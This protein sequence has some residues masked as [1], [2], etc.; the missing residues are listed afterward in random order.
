MKG[1]GENY[2]P[3]G[4]PASTI[5]T[6]A[7]GGDLFGSFSIFLNPPIRFVGNVLGAY[8][9]RNV[10]VRDYVA[11]AKKE[12]KEKI[13]AKEKEDKE[14]AELDRKRYMEDMQLG[15]MMKQAEADA[16]LKNAKA[17]KILEGEDPT[18]LDRKRYMEDMMFDVEYRLKEKEL[19]SR[20]RRDS[21]SGSVINNNVY[22]NIRGGN[23]DI[24]QEGDNIN[25]NP[26]LNNSSRAEGGRTEIINDSY[27]D[28]VKQ[29]VTGTV[30]PL[31]TDF[32]EIEAARRRIMADKKSAN[33]YVV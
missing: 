8:L 32:S 16:F 29:S 25:V 12:I 26:N 22:P 15:Y 23:V 9:D 2:E 17:T 21:N 31:G 7:T 30:I 6:I 10:D 14:N 19:R 3:T 33:A 13:K 18:E 11:E 5:D 1:T 28:A 24:N 27:N 4:E 20:R